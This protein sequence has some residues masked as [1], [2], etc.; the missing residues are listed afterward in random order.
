MDELF[1]EAMNRF[2]D[3]LERAKHAGIAEPCAMSVATADTSG[4][5]SV[6]MVLLR[7]V[8]ERG[9]VFLKPI[10]SVHQARTT[11]HLSHLRSAILRA[12]S[13]A[14]ALERQL[15]TP[16]LAFSPTHLIRSADRSTLKAAS[17]PAPRITYRSF[18]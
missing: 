10:Q 14:G 13:I 1:C 5:P 7:G 4:R 17:I 3:L 2:Y 8:D 18:W 15:R 16:I 12:Q 9:V 6:R 11:P